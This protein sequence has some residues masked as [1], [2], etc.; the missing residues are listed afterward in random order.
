MDLDRVDVKLFVS[1]PE[2]VEWS[3]YTEIFTRWRDEDPE[4]WLDIADYLHM[5]EGPGLLLVGKAIH[6]SIDNRHGRPGL[7]YSRREPSDGTTSE[8]IAQA[9]KET[10]ELAAAL[11]REDG[12]GIRFGTESVDIIANDRVRFPNIGQAAEAVRGDVS[13]AVLEV[14]GERPV[15]MSQEADERERLTFHVRVGAGRPVG[16]VLDDLGVKV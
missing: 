2:S 11:E 1:N 4:R 3:D 8:R 16:Q 9:L 6:V 14:F 10:L 13:D 5:H 7:L 15:E 12:I